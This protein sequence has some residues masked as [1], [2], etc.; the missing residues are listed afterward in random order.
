MA[1]HDVR[2]D[3]ESNGFVLASKTLHGGGLMPGSKPWEA[4]LTA[5]EILPIALDREDPVNVRVV[6]GGALEVAELAEWVGQVQGGLRVPDGQLALCGGAAYVIDGEAWTEEYARIVPVPAGDYRASVYVYASAP[7][8]RACL[9]RASAD[10]PLGSWFRRTRPGQPMPA[11]LHN[12]LVSDPD[13]DPGHESEWKRARERPGGQVIDLLVHLEPA[14]GPL[15]P[16]PAEGDGFALAGGGRRP[17]PFPLGLAA[18]DQPAPASPPPPPVVTPVATGELSPITEGPVDVLVAKLA[19][20]F[21]VAWFCHPYT[22]PRLLV[23]LPPGAARPP[24]AEIDNVTFG[25]E[26]REISIEIDTQG[27]PDY[28]VAALVPVGKHLAAVP[29]GS[30]IELRTAR[31][32]AKGLLGA[33]RYR[34]TVEGGRWRLAASSPSVPAARLAEALALA[35]A[36]ELGK[37]LVA[38]DAAEA[39]RLEARVMQHAPDAFHSNPLLRN[40]AELSVRRRDPRAITEL[41][42]RAFWM[43]YADSWPLRDLDLDET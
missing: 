32:R 23:E 15:T 27:Q 26:G 25:G 13:Q 16:A 12:A 41:A 29:D 43:R 11:W 37:T 10:E 14:K 19:R 35:E 9:E 28:A 22:Q 7:N 34:G 24:V 1:R 38:R 20:V 42:M 17:E 36:A 39:E 2:V 30:V 31:A 33:H 6:V 18:P 4:A 3:N 8:A 5:C 21:R 40:G